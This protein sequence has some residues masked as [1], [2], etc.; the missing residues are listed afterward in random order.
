MPY[1]GSCSNQG[2]KASWQHSQSLGSVGSRPRLLLSTRNHQIHSD[3]VDFTPDNLLILTLSAL[4]IYTSQVR[5]PILFLV[6]MTMWAECGIRLLCS[7]HVGSLRFGHIV[8][9][10]LFDFFF[11]RLNEAD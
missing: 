6:Q 7:G 1:G 3:A 9:K 5:F 10:L 2:H 11:F 8:I 4:S